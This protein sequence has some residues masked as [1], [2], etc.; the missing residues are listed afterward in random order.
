LEH[1]LYKKIFIDPGSSG[2]PSW[3]P[4]PPEDEDLLFFIQRNQNAD[5]IVYRV[6]RNLDGL[7]NK[8]LPMDAYW[9]RY[10][11][12]GSRWELSEIQSK[13]AYGYQSSIITNELFSFQF[14]SYD[15]ITFFITAT[16]DEK[17]YQAVYQHNDQNIVLDNIYVYADE[18]G[19]FPVVKYIELF[20]KIQ[21]T[22]E[23]HYRNILIAK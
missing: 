10:T 22:Q 2:R 16:D 6:N 9:I 20:G 18:M 5:T 13:L 1:E 3:Y 11:D 21:G 17:R 19:V 12:G 4:T 7:I 23:P 15:E 8:D 14:V